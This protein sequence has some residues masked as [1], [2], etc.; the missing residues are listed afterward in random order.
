MSAEK[1]QGTFWTFEKTNLILPHFFLNDLK[2]LIPTT[3]AIL[4]FIVALIPG[5]SCWSLR[6]LT[7]IWLSRRQAYYVVSSRQSVVLNHESNPK[8]EA[9]SRACKL[10]LRGQ[11]DDVRPSTW[12][13]TPLLH[14]CPSPCMASSR[15]IMT[16]N[17][18]RK[19]SSVS[20][21]GQSRLTQWHYS[22]SPSL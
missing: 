22:K 19:A 16:P 3:S 11:A 9:E 13:P 2:T 6:V 10:S 14:T 21:Q 12:N 1:A 5:F 8:K 7:N 15:A 18:M 20:V 17:S 4:P